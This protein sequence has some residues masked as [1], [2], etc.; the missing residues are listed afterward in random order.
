MLMVVVDDKLVESMRAFVTAA[1]RLDYL[2]HRDHVDLA[3]ME[4]ASREHRAAS[5]ALQE[6]LVSRGWRRPGE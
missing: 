2:S 6:A 1:N 4:A 3:L 5:D